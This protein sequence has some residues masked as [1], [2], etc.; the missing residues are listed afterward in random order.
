MEMHQHRQTYFEAHLG[1][2]YFPSSLNAQF[3]PFGKAIA[4]QKVPGQC[5]IPEYV[6]LK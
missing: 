5:H 3:E 1:Q 2:A 4:Y 6:H